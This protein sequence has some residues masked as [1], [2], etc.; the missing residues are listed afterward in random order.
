MHNRMT[1]RR[2]YLVI[3]GTA[4]LSLLAGC[5]SQETDNNDGTATPED[6]YTGE[7]DAVEESPEETS[8]EKPTESDD[9][10]VN[11]ITQLQS[12][13]SIEDYYDPQY[14]SFQGN[15]VAQTEAWK[16]PGGVVVVDGEIEDP[17]ELTLVDENGD[18]VFQRSSNT[19]Q[20]RV[21]CLAVEE[22]TYSFNADTD[23][24]WSVVVARP[25]PSESEVQTPPAAANGTAGTDIVGPIDFAGSFTA[26]ASAGSHTPSSSIFTALAFPS[27]ATSKRDR[28][29]LFGERLP[30]ENQETEASIS[31]TTWIYIQSS[32]D[33][34]I[35]FE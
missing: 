30:V 22:G 7:T 29:I 2:K 13:T 3:G 10:D 6:S 24:L 15:G 17:F 1:T 23:G 20:S 26:T 14:V 8:T 21:W 35:I 18:S 5:A 31:G 33:W 32:A 9:S 12:V 28:E 11:E 19:G 34:E 27:D 25:D 4:S 16:H